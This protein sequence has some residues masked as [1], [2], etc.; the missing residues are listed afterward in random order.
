ML[1]CSITLVA[2][3]NIV[4]ILRLLY[5]KIGAILF[6]DYF[7]QNNPNTLNL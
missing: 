7:K 4:A 5:K 2:L 6:C 1:Y 3:L